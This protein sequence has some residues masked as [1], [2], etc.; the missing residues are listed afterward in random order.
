MIRAIMNGC[1]GVMGHVI[2]ASSSKD[3]AIESVAG[4]HMHTAH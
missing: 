2:T 1:L 4:V 3:D